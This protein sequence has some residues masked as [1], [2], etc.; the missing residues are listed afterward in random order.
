MTCPIYGCD[1]PRPGNAAICG[2]CA[3][4][5]RRDLETI[6]ELTHELDIT[7]SR[8]TAM[9]DG[10]GGDK[11]LPYNSRASD[12]GAL[13]RDT[14]TGWT[15]DLLEA[16]PDEPRP[17]STLPE[18][19]S[20][21]LDRM[22]TLLRHP[23]VVDIAEEIGAVVDQA[24]RAVDRPADKQYSG[25]CPDCGEG[26]Y[27]RQ[28]AVQVTCRGCGSDYDM[29]DRKACLLTE[30][31]G[32]LA[33]ASQVANILTQLLGNGAVLQPRTVR[34]WALRK[35]VFAHGSDQKG[36]PLYLVAECEKKFVEELERQH[37]REAR[38]AAKVAS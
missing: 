5:L 10:Q 24:R 12:A 4:Q 36:R 29:Q 9:G 20:W 14:L 21:L 13:L 11:P 26:L 31:Q 17:G 38:Q 18:L 37:N 32:T 2:A 1:R 8:Q 28:G 22:Q 19:A 27:A 33:T 15:R 35:L 25:P 3:S 6:P 7:L 34:N 16:H 30:V 23:A